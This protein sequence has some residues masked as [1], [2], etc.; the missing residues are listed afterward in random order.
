MK[1]SDRMKI[2]DCVSAFFAV[3]I[4]AFIIINALMIRGHKI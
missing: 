1:K 4:P 3:D 2:D